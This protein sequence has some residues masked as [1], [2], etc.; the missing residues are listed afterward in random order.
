MSHSCATGCGKPAN[1][2]ICPDCTADVVTALRRLATGGVLRVRIH[3]RGTGAARTSYLRPDTRPGLYEDLIDTLARKDHTGGLPIGGGGGGG[4]VGVTFHAMASKLKDAIDN[5]ISTW[6]RDVAAINGREL[7]A[8]TIR[9]AAAWLAA[10]GKLLAAHPAAD[11]LHRAIT[12]LVRAAERCVD[13]APERA[14]LGQCGNITS[15]VLCEH[16]IYVL[17]HRP[18]AQCEACGA[19]WNVRGR[20]DY[21]LAHVAD[22]LATPPEISKALSTLG[23]HVTENMI[24][25]YAHRATASR[26]KLTPHPPHPLDPRKRTRYRIGDVRAILDTNNQEEAS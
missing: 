25:G 4:D 11:E 10:Q 8:T 6:A 1:A 21:L 14:Y 18:V 24:Y 5:E 2:T 26:A 13:R 16:D 7:P 22:Q 17:P 12:R 9:D 19:I 15:D 20:R 23:Q 3:Y